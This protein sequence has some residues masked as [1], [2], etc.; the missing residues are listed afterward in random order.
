MVRV[1]ER[2]GKQ[3]IC[4]Q[5]TST[6]NDSATY[7][8]TCDNVCGGRN[9]ATLMVLLKTL[10]SDSFTKHPNTLQMTRGVQLFYKT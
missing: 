4:S 10:A 8:C 5:S 1:P 3:S 9:R 6:W 7:V 2:N